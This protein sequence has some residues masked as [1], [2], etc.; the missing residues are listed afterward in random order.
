MYTT[1][2]FACPA[3]DDC[4]VLHPLPQ[5]VTESKEGGEHSPPLTT[6]C[7]RENLV[8][9]L[10]FVFLH[11]V[12]K[13]PEHAQHQMAHIVTCW[14]SAACRH[15][16]DDTSAVLGLH[17]VASQAYVHFECVH[18]QCCKEVDSGVLIQGEAGPSE[19]HVHHGKQ[20][21]QREKTYE[22]VMGSASHVRNYLS[23]RLRTS[24]H[25]HASHANSGPTLSAILAQLSIHRKSWT[26]SSSAKRTSSYKA[27]AKRLASSRTLYSLPL[28]TPPASDTHRLTQETEERRQVRTNMPLNGFTS[29]G[30][31]R[32][33]HQRLLKSAGDERQ[34]TLTVPQRTRLLGVHA[35][36]QWRRCAVSAHTGRLH[37]PILRHPHLQE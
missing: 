1:N 19:V 10:F 30:T 17:A 20:V 32:L 13:V 21:L 37:L 29:S 26:R 24:T 3:T 34:G 25:A 23:L 36:C 27:Q 12:S 15:G 14:T 9:F 22:Q 6:E 18:L 16:S 33:G 35:H 7:P 2:L 31:A 4:P 8:L 5:L 11:V 28:P